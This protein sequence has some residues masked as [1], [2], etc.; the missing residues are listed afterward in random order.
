MK[1]FVNFMKTNLEFSLLSWYHNWEE[2]CVP[3]LLSSAL[4]EQ[5]MC[6]V[7]CTGCII[8]FILQLRG[9]E[10]SKDKKVHL[11]YC[12]HWSED[13]YGTVMKQLWLTVNNN[14]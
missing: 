2:F 6:F 4:D 9:I 3:I 13:E 14:P 1:C 7:K 8:S 11:A 5:P 12:K 10:Y